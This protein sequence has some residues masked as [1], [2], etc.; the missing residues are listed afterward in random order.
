MNR[1]GAKDVSSPE[2]GK[3]RGVNTNMAINTQKMVTNKRKIFPTLC[4]SKI[5]GTTKPERNTVSKETVK[6]MTIS[7]LIPVPILPA[8]GISRFKRVTIMSLQWVKGKAFIATCR[9]NHFG[10][11]I[12]IFT[13]VC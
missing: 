12:S 4:V 5:S 6:A 8:A 2:Y 9:N 7:E 1:C 13:Y 3:P 10:P 11:R